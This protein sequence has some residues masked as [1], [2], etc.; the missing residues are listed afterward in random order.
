MIKKIIHFILPFI[1]LSVSN[2]VLAKEDTPPPP[3]LDPKYM[4][5]H[6][7]KLL[8]KGSSVFASHMLTLKAPKNVQI[9]YKLDINQ[10]FLL[11]LVKDADLV[12]IKP[13]PFNLQRL[14]RGEKVEVKADIYMGNYKKDGMLTYS[15]VTIIFD[16]QLF[17][18]IID[19]PEESNKRQKYDVV[20]MKN[21][22][23][24]LIHQ[25]QKPPSYEHII[26]LSD[27]VNCITNFTS[28]SAVPKENEIHY[29]LTYC[30]AMKPLYYNAEDFL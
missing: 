8:N 22:E 20:N 23:R 28:S 10:L 15:D 9:L 13:E 14:M 6:G 21:N 24:I 18:K 17:T 11:Q 25:I 29:K 19:K 30:G 2:S 1:I 5:I 12:T 3:P 7:M 27:D 26:Y 4:G 16:K